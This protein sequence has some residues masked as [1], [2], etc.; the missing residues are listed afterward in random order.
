M[1]TVFD[2]QGGI[3]IFGEIKHM[4]WECLC[5]KH[6]FEKATCSV[7]QP[8]LDVLEKKG[9]MR[10][11]LKITRS[12]AKAHHLDQQDVLMVFRANCPVLEHVS[13]K[14]GGHQQ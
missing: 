6:F 7:F 10:S 11:V 9:R 12:Q 4:A 1:V 3:D 14:D 2:E 5:T 13:W 8:E